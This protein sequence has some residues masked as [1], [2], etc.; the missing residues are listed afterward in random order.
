[1]KL[2][3]ASQTMAKNGQKADLIVLLTFHCET[4]FVKSDTVNLGKPS[5]EGYL[6][7][8]DGPNVQRQL[9]TI[10]EGNVGY[11]GVRFNWPRKLGTIV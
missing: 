1:M 5:A 10:S 4:K 2:A 3:H 9:W 11:C 8:R 7:D 6:S